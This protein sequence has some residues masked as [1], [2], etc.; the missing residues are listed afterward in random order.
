MTR[1]QFCIGGSQL[2][3]SAYGLFDATRPGV[4]LA[5]QALWPVLIKELPEGVAFDAGMPKPLGEF[6]VA[7]RAMAAGGAPVQAMTLGVSLGKTSKTVAVFGDRYWEPTYTGFLASAPRPFTEMQIDLRRSFGGPSHP[8]NS[9]GVGYNANKVVNSGQIAFLPNFENPK[10]LINSIGDS[11]TPLCLGPLDPLRQ[12]LRKLGGSFDRTWQEKIAP[13]LPLD[14][15]PRIYCVAP[16]DQRMAGFFTGTEPIRVS[17]M[18]PDPAGYEGQLPGLRARA[19]VNLTSDAAG[20]YEVDLKIDTVLLLGSLAKGVVVF[21]G[22]IPVKDVDARDAET[23]MLAY[24]RMDEDP[25]PREHYAEVFR[26][27]T[28]KDHAIKYVFAESQLTPRQSETELQRRQKARE[29]YTRSVE[30]RFAEGA[31]LLTRRQFEQAGISPSFL[32]KAI[33]PTRLPVLLPSPEDIDS[34]D[35]DLAD[36]LDS[37]DKETAKVQQKL[38]AL[39]VAGEAAAKSGN[40]ADLTKVVAVLDESVD[41]NLVTSVNRGLDDSSALLPD[42]EEFL[43]TL[44]QPD[45][46]AG[47]DVPDL[48]GKVR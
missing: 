20:L 40:L 17:G 31:D 46:L 29:D 11:P 39:K 18:T 6:I 47:Q 38:N 8:F 34:G 15:D 26:L 41:P 48:L 21:R 10:Q 3:I 16:E 36:M 22:S 45:K 30:K 19:F 32:P 44:S 33:E 35:I 14:S 37:L 4:F 23:V 2:V 28:H 13:A 42:F 24:E 9:A 7:G 5:D 27:R 43:S 12:E 25:K 1:T